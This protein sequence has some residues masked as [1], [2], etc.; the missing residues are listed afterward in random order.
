MYFLG[1]GR[2]CNDGRA[3]SREEPP[4]LDSFPLGFLGQICATAALSET[5]FPTLCRGGT[6]ME[7]TW[8]K[9][10]T[11]HPLQYLSEAYLAET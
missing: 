3:L 1:T 8:R 10:C 11:N 2:G 7:M 4:R 9:P 5:V 6:E